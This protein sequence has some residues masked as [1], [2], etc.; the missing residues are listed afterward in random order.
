M[1]VILPA[2]N[3]P[4]Q[5]ILQE[6]YGYDAFRG[7]QKAAIDRALAGQDSLVLMPTGGGKSV[8]YQIPAQLGTGKDQSTVLVVSPLIALMQDQVSALH[9]LGVPAAFL[10]SSLSHHEQDDVIAQL[11]NGQLRLLYIA[12]ERLVQPGT[13][14][15]LRDV[16]IALIAIDEAHC[17]SQWGHDF[18]QDYLALHELRN[19]FPGVPRMAL[20]ATA[21]ELTRT[22]IIERLALTNA[23]TLVSDFDRPNIRYQVQAKTDGSSQLNT[24]LQRHKGEA[25]IIYCLSRKKTESTAERLNRQGYTALPYHAGLPP[26][27]RSEHQRRFLLEDGV[28]IVATIA[29]GMGID[30][31]DVRFVAHLDLPKSLEAY[32]Q[33]TGRAG[34]DGEP[35][36][37]WMIYGLQDVVR[38]RQM[39]EESIAGEEYKRHER[40]KLDT[41]L[42]WCE[43]TSCRR[44]PLL[45]YFGEQADAECGNCDNCQQPPATRDGTEDAQKLLSTVYRTG[46]RF[47]AAHVVDVLL[48][49]DTAKIKQHGHTQLSVF[50]I[51]IGKPAQVW[52][53][54]IRQLVVQGCLRVDPERFGALVL[55]ESSRSVLRGEETLHL[56][57]D[58]AAPRSG[59]GGGKKTR[60]GSATADIPTADLPL[61]EALRECRQRLALEYNVPPYVIFHDK[62]LRQML[63]ERSA[64]TDAFLHL[65]GVG[66]A[67]LERYGDE[68]M[69]VI[70]EHG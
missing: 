33:E 10:N 61:W 25:G 70:R 65:S 7:Q 67:K 68:F 60:T 11:R 57:E 12:P 47:G 40:Q 52:R 1:P 16:N 55:T 26:E 66:Q 17:V 20:T 58:P 31:P 28:I 59:K 13:R 8:C 48:G 43:V 4:A 36:E 22:E 41:L 15:M 64:D 29:F 42:G 50:G 32:Y 46:Q 19:W 37:A 69:A 54:A 14:A 35:A 39:A 18:R 6:V 56:R 23:A 49:K 9:A 30:K 2:V 53:S 3:S 45:A 21:T 51:G 38:L 63:S 34:R 44:T 27:T 5:Q 62:T 24:F